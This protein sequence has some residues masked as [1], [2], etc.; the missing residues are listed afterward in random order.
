MMPTL[1]NAL[2]RFATGVTIVTCLDANGEPIGL[3]ANSF[4]ALSLEPPLILWSLRRVSP[5]LQAFAAT[6]YFAVNVL[7]ASQMELSRRFASSVSDKFA[8]GVWRAGHGGVPVLGEAAALFE[9]EVL[10]QQ[11]AGDHMLFIGR[12][13]YFVDGGMPPL[14]FHAGR[15]HGL[16]EVM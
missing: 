16:G 9:C 10:S 11:E 12:V 5:S 7:G 1:R 8:D 4:G 2:G 13:L 14:L 3:T 6:R 15:Y